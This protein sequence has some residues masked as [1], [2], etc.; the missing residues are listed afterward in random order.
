MV[1][2][3]GVSLGLETPD[4]EVVTFST[5]QEGLTS[6]ANG[7]RDDDGKHDGDGI[8]GDD[9]ST[10]YVGS[11]CGKLFGSGHQ[12]RQEFVPCALK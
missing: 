11:P 8:R 10:P 2:R 7:R 3:E 6:C 5:E 12:S 4:F 1:H 9:G